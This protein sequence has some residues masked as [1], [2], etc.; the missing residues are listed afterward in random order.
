MKL[1]PFIE[2]IIKEIG[3]RPAGTEAEFK[4][5]RIVSDELKKR[6]AEVTS[7]DVKVCPGIITGLINL[8]TATYLI[9]ML[10]YFFVPIASAVLVAA[11]LA[12]LLFSRQF[13]N[14]VIDWLFSKTTTRN[15]IG[16]YEPKGEAKQVLIFSGH[17]DSPDMMPLLSPPTKR[18]VHLI[19]NGV[20]LG[21]ALLIPAGILRA[22]L[23][24]PVLW[25]PV[26]LAWYDILW[27]ISLAGLMLG[28]YYRSRM[29]T[30]VHNLGANDNLSAV[31]V[32]VG[33]ADYL[34]ATPPKNTEIY[35]VS[36]GS[37][38]P[39]MYGS[40]GF[41]RGNLDLIKK[42]LNVNMETV[43]A[44]KLGII[45][46]EKMYMNAYSP[47]AIGLIERAGKRRASSCRRSL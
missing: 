10:V 24:G 37:E 26:H 29:I 31:A 33:I 44:G 17:H 12:M 45:V 28:I 8:M 23:A 40:D 22:I 18:F 3:P 27:V 15:I 4:A 43:G 32:L 41:A 39:F 9:S 47:E 7:Q 20:V 25:L 14:G 6:G 16:R 13:G 5:G 35:L 42:A 2:R 46:K 30:G 1:K 38:E 11:L 21:M 36:F 34:K 19:E